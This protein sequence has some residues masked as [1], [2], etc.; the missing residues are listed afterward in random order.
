VLF[1]YG[2]FF[3]PYSPDANFRRA[4]DSA[5][6]NAFLFLFLAACGFAIP[7]L[8]FNPMNEKI[9]LITGGSSGIGLALARQLAQLG[10][11]LALAARSPER[12]QC[13]ASEFPDNAHWFLCDVAD[14]LAVGQL[15]ADVDRQFGRIDIL[16]NVAGYAAVKSIPDTTLEDWR[17]TFDINVTSIYAAT[18]ACWPIFQRQRSGFVVN[19]SSMASRDPFPGFFAYAAAKAAVNMLTLTT[20]REGESIGVRAVCIAPGAVETPMLRS[21]F[22]SKM[23]PPDAA[24]HPDQVAQ[25]ITDCITGQRDFTPGQTIF[26]EK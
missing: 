7:R 16:A 12:L 17:T 23:V 5:C 9:A 18:R 21:L 8:P 19:V 11:T 6:L 15:I 14:P 24:I 22:D 10:Y 4:A 20:A 1:F 26:V 13:A 25:V 2:R 3:I